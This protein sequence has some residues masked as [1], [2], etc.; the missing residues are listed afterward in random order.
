MVSS[1]VGARR[2]KKAVIGAVL[3]ALTVTTLIG[4]PTLAHA[5]PDGDVGTADCTFK[6]SQNGTVRTQSSFTEDL[7]SGEGDPEPALNIDNV[8]TNGSAVSLDLDCDLERSVNA[9]AVNYELSI[10]TTSNGASGCRA[11]GE[12]ITDDSQVTTVRA[13][14]EEAQL[15]FVRSIAEATAKCL[16][17]ASAKIEELV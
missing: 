1:V 5:D 13:E 4:T 2:Q 7:D 15:R 6:V 10:A 8:V 3:A 11:N 16:K 12:Y 9:P 17:I 14:A